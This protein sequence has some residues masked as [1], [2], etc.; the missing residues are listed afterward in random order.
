MA[1]WDLCEL[2]QLAERFECQCWKLGQG[3]DCG[4][5]Q[6]REELGWGEAS[7]TSPFGSSKQGDV[8]SW[9]LNRRVVS[10]PCELTTALQSLRGTSWFIWLETCQLVLPPAKPT[11]PKVRKNL[12]LTS[13]VTLLWLQVSCAGSCNGR[14]G[15][16]GESAPSPWLGVW[17]VPRL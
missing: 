11:S 6:S 14:Y 15:G 4:L 1:S 5:E 12:S 10:G 8:I 16:K 13:K 9:V 3:W 17:G 2:N 7:E